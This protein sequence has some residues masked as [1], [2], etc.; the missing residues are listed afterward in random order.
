MSGLVC[1]AAH[2]PEGIAV[3]VLR[4]YWKV[5]RGDAVCV[6]GAGACGNCTAS[7]VPAVLI[8]RDTVKKQAVP[9]T[10]AARHGPRCKFVSACLLAGSLRPGLEFWRLETL[11]TFLRSPA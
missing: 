3:A 8:V 7:H 5:A 10:V 6:R 2:G 1:G 11:P 9:D 4:R